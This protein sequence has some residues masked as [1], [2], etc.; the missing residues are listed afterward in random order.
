MD[1]GLQH[2]TPAF[3]P[4]LSLTTG[5]HC[6]TQTSRVSGLTGST[7]DPY[8]VIYRSCELREDTRRNNVC[9][10]L[11]VPGR[12]SLCSLARD[13]E[14]RGLLPAAKSLF[15]RAACPDRPILRVVRDVVP[16]HHR[17]MGDVVLQLQAMRKPDRQ[18]PGRKACR[19]RHQLAP[20]RIAAFAI[21]HFAGTQVP[22]G[23]GGYVATESVR[24][25][26]RLLTQRR[27]QDRNV[28]FEPDQVIRLVHCGVNA[29]GIC[30]T[31]PSL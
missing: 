20:H 13:D 11:W 31:T 28:Q 17:A 7:P 27:R 10:W 24:L 30:V 12:R 3:P 4:G 21:Q 2:R 19:C 1:G 14:K 8:R 15:P 18:G 5:V 22:F 16:A 26:G 23:D 25:P 9:L 29:S 6:I